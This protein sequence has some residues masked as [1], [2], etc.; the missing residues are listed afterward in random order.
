MKT[1]RVLIG[2]FFLN[3]D[4][5]ASAH[6][7]GEKLYLRFA[8]GTFETLYGENADRVWR[9][10]QGMGHHLDMSGEGEKARE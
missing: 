9:V 4:A 1:E 7:E 2:K 5:V 10:L 6:W 3:L 8:T